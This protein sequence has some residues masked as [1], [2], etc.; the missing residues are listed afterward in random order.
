MI[1]GLVLMFQ[2]VHAQL[3]M[4][5]STKAI[6][7]A[8][9]M[10]FDKEAHY[11]GD[12]PAG[13]PVTAVFEFENKGGAPLVI[14]GTKGSCGCTVTNYTK[15]AIASGKKGYVTATYNAKKPGS[16]AK[17][18]TVFANIEGSSKILTIKGVVVE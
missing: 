10:V 8:P 9:L 5:E 1:I 11:F 6:P 13:E 4:N 16:F 7:L 18:V 12:I 15:D 2:S 14:T 17:T 3:A